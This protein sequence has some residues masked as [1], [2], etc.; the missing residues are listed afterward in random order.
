MAESRPAG[1]RGPGGSARGTVAGV[2]AGG[3]HHVSLNV[4]DI[5]RSLAFY[6]D[7]LGLAAVP[8]PAFSFAGAWLDAGDGR[9]VHLIETTNVP[10]DLGQHFAFRVGDLDAAIDRIRNAGYQV[11]DPT[12]VAD[13]TIRQAF[14]VDPDGN[15]VEFTQP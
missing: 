11:S 4:T 8:R 1:T 13:T 6:C 14:A 2:I 7:T 9:Q 5:G 12:S 15:R 10:P 3:I